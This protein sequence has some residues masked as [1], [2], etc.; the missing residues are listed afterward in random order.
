MI[1]LAWSWL[2]HQPD[3]AVS[4]WFRERV[5]N[6]NGRIRRITIVAMARKLLALWH[7]LETGVLPTGAVLKVQKT[8]PRHERKECSDPRWM[9]DH[10]H[11]WLKDAAL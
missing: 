5:G 11:D 1:E 6:L 9:C 8:R 4:V 3:S 7:Y 10:S 2:R